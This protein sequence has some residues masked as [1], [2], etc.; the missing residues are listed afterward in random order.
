MGLRD[1]TLPIY[2]PAEPKAPRKRRL[3]KLDTSKHLWPYVRRV[4]GKNGCLQWQRSPDGANAYVTL[5]VE[6]YPYAHRVAAEEAL[7]RK[8]R[9][10][11]CALHE[12]HN[13]LCCLFGPGHI[14][15]GTHKQN[16]ADAI[17]RGTHAQRKLNKQKAREIIAHKNQGLT[18]RE[19]APMYGVTRNT[20]FRICKGIRWAKATADLREPSQSR[21]KRARAPKEAV[22]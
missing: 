11:E 3:P 7:G 17:E 1:T 20:V 5:K 4:G 2:P 22:S 9:K 13:P 14:Y 19:I 8:L 6:G 10:N 18:Y 21:V 16:V 15:I 12:C